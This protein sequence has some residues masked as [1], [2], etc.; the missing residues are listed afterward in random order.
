[1]G[2]SLDR[3]EL[4]TYASC[5]Y[6]AYLRRHLEEAF[7]WNDPLWASGPVWCNPCWQASA[8][9]SSDGLWYMPRMAFSYTLSARCPSRKGNA[10]RKATRINESLEV[11][12]WR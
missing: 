1:M 11:V 5:E 9:R 2:D 7:Q 4:A 8:G 12:A 6:R 3:T 10:R